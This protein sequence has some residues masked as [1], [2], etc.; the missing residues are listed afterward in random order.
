VLR[1][2]GFPSLKRDSSQFRT[3]RSLLDSSAF[4]HP[5][6]FEEPGASCRPALPVGRKADSGTPDSDDASPPGLLGAVVAHQARPGGDRP[7]ISRSKSESNPAPDSTVGLSGL[8]RDSCALRWPE[9]C[10]LQYEGA[11]PDGSLYPRSRLRATLCISS[12][13]GGAGDGTEESTRRVVRPISKKRPASAGWEPIFRTP[14]AAWR[15][16]D[17]RH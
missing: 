3:A 11:L 8:R 2:G 13:I 7:I 4:K 15:M 16:S 17:I 14:L 9:A 6:L 10:G 12:D 5:S 1:P